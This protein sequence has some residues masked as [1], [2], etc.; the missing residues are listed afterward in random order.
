VARIP[1]CFSQGRKRQIELS[2]IRIGTNVIILYMDAQHTKH[3]TYKLA[4]HFVWCPK[5]RKRILTGKIAAFVEQEIRRICE[6]NTWTIGADPRAGRSCASL[7][8]RFPIRYS[9]TDCS[10]PERHHCPPGLSTLSRS[11]ET[12]LGW[13]L[14]VSFVLRGQCWR[15]ERSYCIK[16]YRVGTGLK[17]RET[18][19]GN[20]FCSPVDQ[21]HD[22]SKV[23]VIRSTDTIGTLQLDS[24]Q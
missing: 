14:M 19:D 20:S 10:H 18:K 11:Q 13:Y 9:L 2:S 4:Y 15:Y 23:L 21:Y 5:Y 8:Q 1:L 3:A 12:A 6:I 16:I 7:S 24:F 22:A 17:Q